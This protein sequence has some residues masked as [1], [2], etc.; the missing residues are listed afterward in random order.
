MDKMAWGKSADLEGL[1]QSLEELPKFK[2]QRE[3]EES[4]KNNRNC[5]KR[6]ERKTGAFEGQTLRK[7]FKNR[8]FKKK[9][10]CN[11]FNFYQEK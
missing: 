4:A 8:A 2:S 1:W 11:Y 5:P 6:K 9:E 10:R 3:E 7:T